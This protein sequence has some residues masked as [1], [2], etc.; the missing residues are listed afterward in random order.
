MNMLESSKKIV[1]KSIENASNAP[2]GTARK[3]NVGAHDGLRTRRVSTLVLRLRN[4]QCRCR[5]S[6][7]AVLLLVARSVRALR[8]PVSWCQLLDPLAE[9]GKC[10]EFGVARKVLSFLR[11]EWERLVLVLVS[12]TDIWNSC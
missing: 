2:Y 5:L 3:E 8:V 6:L 4:N 1:N 11:T 12:D 9:R 10:T 7:F